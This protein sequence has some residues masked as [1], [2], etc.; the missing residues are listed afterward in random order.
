MRLKYSSGVDL[1]TDIGNETRAKHSPGVNWAPG[2]L[3]CKFPGMAQFFR[4]AE[5][6]CLHFMPMSS[7]NLCLRGNSLWEL[8]HVVKGSRDILYT[9]VYKLGRWRNQEWLHPGPVAPGLR[10]SLVEL[11]LRPMAWNSELLTFRAGKEWC[12]SFRTHQDSPLLYL[13]VLGCLPAV[14]DGGSYPLI[15]SNVCV[16]ETL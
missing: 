15:N 7:S 3:R 10:K 11:C 12:P 5:P 4:E 9:D 8:S 2:L 1:D 14:I 13:A 6:T 16:S